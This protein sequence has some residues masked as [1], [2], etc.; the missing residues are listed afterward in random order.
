[1]CA[2]ESGT[3]IC[4]DFGFVHEGLLAVGSDKHAMEIAEVRGEL[5]SFLKFE[6]GLARTFEP[7]IRLAQ[8]FVGL[9][10]TG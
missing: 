4:F 6:L 7:E 3:T 1:M 2:G 10:M 5:D 9:E 8:K